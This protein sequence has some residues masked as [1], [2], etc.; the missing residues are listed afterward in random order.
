[1]QLRLKCSAAIGLGVLTENVWSPR[2]KTCRG[3][4]PTRTRPYE[5]MALRTFVNTPPLSFVKTSR[6]TVSRRSRHRSLMS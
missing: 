3:L 2:P 4:D 1:M 5:F 6:F